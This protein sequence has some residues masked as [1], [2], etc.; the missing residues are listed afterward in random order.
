MKMSHKGKLQGSLDR[1]HL[2]HHTYDC[3]QHPNLAHTGNIDV[4][5][6]ALIMHQNYYNELE[7]V[8]VIF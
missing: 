1:L 7:R 3:I 8:D 4:A 6:L 2:I 5:Y